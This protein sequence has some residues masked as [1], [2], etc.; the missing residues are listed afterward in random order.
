MCL[1]GMAGIEEMATVLVRIGKGPNTKTMYAGHCEATPEGV[2]ALLGV[3]PLVARR[4]LMKAGRFVPV[5]STE[6]DESLP[7]FVAVITSKTNRGYDGI[8]A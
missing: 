8:C 4:A 1:G 3:S 2:S 7:M 6:H 5:P